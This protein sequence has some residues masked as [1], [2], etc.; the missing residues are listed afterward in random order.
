MTCAHGTKL[1]A[2]YSILAGWNDKEGG[3][4]A[5]EDKDQGQ[6]YNANAKGVY[7]HKWELN[8]LAANYS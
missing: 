3:L 6:R 7:F 8:Y 4:R 5:S 2:V 1:E